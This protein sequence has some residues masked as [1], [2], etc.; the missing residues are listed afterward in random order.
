MKLES[1][2]KASLY[3]VG[4]GTV[5]SVASMF[6]PI[7]GS[8]DKISAAGQIAA[9]ISGISSISLASLA[10]FAYIK[11]EDVETKLDESRY[12]ALEGLRSDL[13]CV[14]IQMR[15]I[16]QK[17]DVDHLTAGIVDVLYSSLRRARENRVFSLVSGSG[18]QGALD[19]LILVE[20]QV[21]YQKEAY[22][23]SRIQTYELNSAMI[24][25]VFNAYEALWNL[26]V[27]DVSSESLK[28]A[29]RKL[30]RDNLEFL[31]KKAEAV[32]SPRAA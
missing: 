23:H 21:I 16:S 12:A 3:I 8:T 24:L 11:R 14:A 1:L 30:D 9:A 26:N 31:R 22:E 27:S 28:A 5:L 13:A 17:H 2:F 6:T 10:L 20:S 25:A 4:I 19:A 15:L 32:A 18:K 7:L 29:A